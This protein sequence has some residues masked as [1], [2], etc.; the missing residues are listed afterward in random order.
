LSARLLA[1]TF[2]ARG[3]DSESR[4][5]AIAWTRFYEDGEQVW[6]LAQ[7]GDHTVFTGTVNEESEA[8]LVRFG[9]PRSS[10]VELEA[11]AVRGL[12]DRPLPGQ[13]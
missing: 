2:P 5:D 3:G 9:Q 4:A 11:T 1:A 12:T 10:N 13:G 8:R 7:A 6:A